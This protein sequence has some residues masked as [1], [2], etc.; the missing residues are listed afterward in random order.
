MHDSEQKTWIGGGRMLE[1]IVAIELMRRGYE[2][3]VGKLYQKEID[4]VAIKQNEKLYIQ[5]SDYIGD[6]QTFEREINPLLAI[7][8]AYPKILLSRTRQSEYLYE[9]IRVID[10]STWLTSINNSLEQL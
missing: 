6:G 10:I 3:Y 7:K 2:L 5:V 8:D 1:N 4:F 9:G